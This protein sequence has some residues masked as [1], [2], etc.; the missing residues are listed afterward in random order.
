[1]SFF[2]KTDTPNTNSAFN[3]GDTTTT[4]SVLSDQPPK[5]QPFPLVEDDEKFVPLQIQDGKNN[6][7]MMSISFLPKYKNM[8]FEEIRALSYPFKNKTMSFD[9]KVLKSREEQLYELF[10]DQHSFCNT[11]I[12]NGSATWQLHDF[13]LCASP[14]FASL[15]AK[16]EKQAF[17]NMYHINVTEYNFDN[18]QLNTCFMALY[19][20]AF[21]HEFLE[22]LYDV[23]N[24]LGLM[25]LLVMSMQETWNAS[26]G[27]FD[28]TVLKE[29]FHLLQ[30][31]YK[32][33]QDEEQVSKIIKD[34]CY[35]HARLICSTYSEPQLHEFAIKYP[36]I[37]ASMCVAL[38]VPVLQQPAAFSRAQVPQLQTFAQIVWSWHLNELYAQRRNCK[39]DV[40]LVFPSTGARKSAHRAIL[41]WT[42]SF[43]ASMF[44][45]FQEASLDEIEMDESMFE[46]ESFDIAMEYFY[47]MKL[48]KK[49]DIPQI[50]S[51]M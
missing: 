31:K 43:F 36:L 2:A 6:E 24:E 41:S 29:V 37:I 18:T 8:S 16:S 10:W 13:L 19:G 11:I 45:D 46:Q 33:A 48:S 21:P 40:I 47:T 49:L 17:D 23:A 14:F 7:T 3:F 50:A 15:I 35:K 20:V 32:Y 5:E 28:V 9:S 39:P 1:M 22:L 44:R 30:I 12:T 51:G 25:F 34:F 26:M 42:S 4:S 27:K 38:T